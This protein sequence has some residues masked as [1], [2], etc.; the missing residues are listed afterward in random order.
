MLDAAGNIYGT[1]YEDGV[2][3]LGTV[4][5][6]VPPASTGKYSEKVLWSFNGTEHR[7]RRCGSIMNIL[8]EGGLQ[9][10]SP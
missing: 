4:F 1:T 6:L 10:L 3:G 2:Y 5:E 8:G 9:Q 7:T